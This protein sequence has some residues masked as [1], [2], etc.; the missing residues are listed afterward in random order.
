MGTMT[1]LQTAML[2][3]LME[4]NG[5]AQ[6]ELAA[7]FD[8]THA[9]VSRNLKKLAADRLVTLKDDGSEIPVKGS[10]LIKFKIDPNETRAHIIKLTKYGKALKERILRKIEV[11]KLLETP[12]QYKQLPFN[13]QI[14]ERLRNEID[15][16]LERAIEKLKLPEST[17]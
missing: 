8:T 5:C 1:L 2:L 7:E 13:A 4:N 11:P 16:K 17:K 12:E 10:G 9:S 14:V 15:E 3:H 6:C